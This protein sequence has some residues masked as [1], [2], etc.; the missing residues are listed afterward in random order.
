[1]NELDKEQLEAVIY[2]KDNVYKG[3]T[4]KE[5]LKQKGLIKEEYEVGSYYRICNGFLCYQG[6]GDVSYGYHYDRWKTDL[7]MTGI[8]ELMTDKEV[9][10]ELIKGAKKRGFKEGVRVKSVLFPLNTFNNGYCDGRGY[11]YDDSSLFFG[12]IAIFNKGKW[13]ETIEEKKPSPL[14]CHAIRIEA[15]GLVSK[16]IAEAQELIKTIK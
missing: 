13:A 5:L 8:P 2:A 9:E 4:F 15:I 3:K 1:M 11:E 12:G 7:H 6:E 16:A 10:E 14:E